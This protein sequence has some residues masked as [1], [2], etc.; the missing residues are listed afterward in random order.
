MIDRIAQISIPTRDLP[1]ARAFYRDV[2]GLQFL[3]EAPPNLAFFDCGGVRI[4][5]GDGQPAQP[6]T[7]TL[8]YFH[9][10]DIRAAVDQIRAGGATIERDPSL[11]ASL[12]DRD[13]WLAVFRDPDGNTLELISEVVREGGDHA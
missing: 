6:D 7:G 9:V 1:R 11:I 10:R 5:V 12:A 4:L 8:I 3:F 13:V 2:L